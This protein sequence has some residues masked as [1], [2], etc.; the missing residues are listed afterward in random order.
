MTNAINNKILT[1]VLPLKENQEILEKFI[2]GNRE[3][4]TNYPLI[5]IGFGN[6]PE[7]RKY[8]ISLVQTSFTLNL[9]SD[10]IIPL[11]FIEEALKEFQDDKVVVISIPYESDIQG[12][13]PFGPSL[14]RTEILQE[15]YDWEF[16]KGDCECRYMW[17]KVKSLGYK[18]VELDMKAKHLRRIS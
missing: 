6:L 9:D 7:A 17:E 1:V 4:L 16:G 3:L 5:V 8:G 13:L 14:W 18:I 11:D 12:H 15:L 2:E 10:V